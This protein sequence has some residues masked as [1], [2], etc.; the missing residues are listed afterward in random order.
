MSHEK[1]TFFKISPKQKEP[2]TTHTTG[3][4]RGSPICKQYYPFTSE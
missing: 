2:L 3:T 1:L 4:I